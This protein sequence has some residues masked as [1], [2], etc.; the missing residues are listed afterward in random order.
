MKIFAIITAAM[1]FSVIFGT[2]TTGIYYEPK[3]YARMGASTDINIS[4]IAPSPINYTLVPLSSVIIS[5]EV[6]MENNE[7]LRTTEA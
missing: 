4:F 7:I 1:V 2:S 6:Y 5:H 3:G